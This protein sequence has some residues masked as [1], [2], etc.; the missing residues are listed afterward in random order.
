MFKRKEEKKEEVK[1]Q[2][3]QVQGM[4]KNHDGIPDYLQKESIP[5]MV[6]SNKDLNLYELDTVPEVET[7]IMELGGYEFDA[8]NS[9]W[10]KTS[11]PIMNNYGIRKVKTHMESL[12]NKHYITT[13]LKSEEIHEILKYHVQ[14]L[15]RWLK[16]NFKYIDCKLGDL[17]SI[18]AQFDN[19][20]FG[21]MSRSIS[22]GQRNAITGRTRLT[23]STSGDKGFP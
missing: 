22:G 21:V 14:E 10:V 3:P 23:Q 18:V 2:P 11:T 20:C 4:D 16:L 17:S 6:K 5:S 19:R 12:I 13:N 7:F 15:I 8:E 9:K 1:E